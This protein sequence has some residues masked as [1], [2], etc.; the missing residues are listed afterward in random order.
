MKV[1]GKDITYEI[2]RDLDAKLSL[3]GKEVILDMVAESENSFHV[4]HE[5]VGYSDHIQGPESAKIAIAEG[6]KVIEKHFTLDRKGGS[7]DDSFSMEPRDLKN[8]VDSVF[9]AYQCLG[10]VDYGLKSSEEGNIKF[11]RSLYFV[12]DLKVN[13][14]ITADS[15]RSV[16][17]GYGVAP[18]YFDKLLGKK[19]CRDIKMH[20]PVT[21]DDFYDL[22][23]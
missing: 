10:E 2:E 19:V 11:R 23:L 6:A 17:P 1:I 12:K 8:L 21:F 9:T 5:N 3:S 13:D 4:I 14:I 20:Q 16:R 18:R 15:I 22:S 7:P